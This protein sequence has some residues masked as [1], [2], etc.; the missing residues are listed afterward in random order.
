MPA[1]PTATME[2]AVAA[3]EIGSENRIWLERESEEIKNW[4]I[5]NVDTTGAAS[6][7]YLSSAALMLMLFSVINRFI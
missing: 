5:D 1:M 6:A 7:V 4:L 3:I 2:A